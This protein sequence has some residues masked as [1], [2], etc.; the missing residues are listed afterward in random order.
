MGGTDSTPDDTLLGGPIGGCQAARAAVLVHIRPLEDHAANAQV[1]LSRRGCCQVH[2]NA[3]LA[4]VS[5][6]LPSEF[7]PYR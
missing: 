5:H 4:P 1:F 6:N 2:H 7:L 3:C